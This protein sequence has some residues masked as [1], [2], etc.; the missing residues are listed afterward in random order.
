MKLL[1]NNL[2]RYYFDIINNNF[3][4]SLNFNYY[5]NF[6][7]IQIDNI[8]SE[9][10]SNFVKTRGNKI[11]NFDE[12]KDYFINFLIKFENDWPKNLNEIYGSD[13]D[14]IKTDIVNVAV[15]N[16]KKKIIEINENLF[17]PNIEYEIFNDLL[18]KL[19]LSDIIK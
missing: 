19:N 9:F 3:G 12:V 8:W 17:A 2:F 13:N 18:T 7:L 11:D 4:N 6:V 16:I 15:K 5:K 10:Y 14:K 1:K